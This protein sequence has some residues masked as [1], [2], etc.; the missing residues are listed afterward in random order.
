VDVRRLGPVT[1]VKEEPVG[2]TPE[3]GRHLERCHGVRAAAMGLPQGA[4]VAAQSQRAK[5]DCVVCRRLT[6]KFNCKR[7]IT[8]AA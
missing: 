6:P 8:S 2:A 1:G 5:H 7:S 4:K 3:H